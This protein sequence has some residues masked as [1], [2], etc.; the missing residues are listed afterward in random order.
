MEAKEQD[1]Y[2]IKQKLGQGGMAIV[3]LAFDKLRGHDVAL[4]VLPRHFLHDPTFQHRFQLEA[5]TMMMLEHHAIVPV[6]DIGQRGEQPYISMRL[7]KGGSLA[8]RIDRTPL[9]LKEINLIVQRICSALNKAHGQKIVHRDIKPANILFDEDDYAYLSD[10]GVVRLIENTHTVTFV[11][12]PQYMAPEQAHGYPVDAQTDIYQMGVV[13]F[14][15]LTGRIPFQAPTPPALLHQHVYAPIPSVCQ[16]NSKLTENYEA[17]VKQAMAKKK[18][19]RFETAS[20]L[21]NT[22]DSA[23]IRSTLG[24]P[25]LNLPDNKNSVSENSA[26]QEKETNKAKISLS[27]LPSWATL[28]ILLFGGLVFLFWATSRFDIGV[29][30]PMLTVLEA[31]TLQPLPSSTITPIV[32]PSE[33]VV[34]ISTQLDSVGV[35]TAQTFIFESSETRTITPTASLVTSPSLTPTSSSTWTTTPTFTPTPSSTST[36]TQTS[37]STPSA[38]ITQETVQEATSLPTLAP[39][40]ITDLPS[41]ELQNPITFAWDGSPNLSYRVVLRHQDQG[42]IHFSDWMQAFIWEYEIPGDQFGPWEWYVEANNSAISDTGEFWFNP[43][44]NSGGSSPNPT[45]A[46]PPSPED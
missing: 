10:F 23:I 46:P 34:I 12:T 32:V 29:D 30:T 37:S 19:D 33:T 31:S 38:T 22:L 2:R 35:G 27:N 15:M 13:L 20:D 3:Y 26:S 8:E 42:H 6:Y 1:R 17:I 11:G 4:K 18:T 16:L 40:K 43:F 24:S 28:L 39:I 41:G 44:P 21:A 36:A 14:Q 45:S 25:L 9:S 5:K 7:M